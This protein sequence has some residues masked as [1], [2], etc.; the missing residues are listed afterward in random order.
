MRKNWKKQ[1]LAFESKFLPIDSRGTGS[2]ERNVLAAGALSLLA[3]ADNLVGAPDKGTSR[4][5]RAPG[6]EVVERLLICQSEARPAAALNYEVEI[7]CLLPEKEEG[8]VNGGK[9][10]GLCRD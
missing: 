3:S 7:S 5:S 4:P 1:A 6:R 10:A 9:V 2:Q 8:E